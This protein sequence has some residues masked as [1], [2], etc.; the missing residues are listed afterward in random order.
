M[1]NHG[2]LPRSGKDIDLA[3]IQHATSH[4]FNYAPD[5]FN[6]AFQMVQDFHLSTTGNFSTFNLQDVEKHD[7]IEF[8]G[9][10]SRNDHYFGDNLHFDPAIWRTVAQ[11]LDLY[12]VPLFGKG[13]F[14]TLDAA[15]KAWAARVKEAKSVN[16]VFNSSALE[17]M[18][19]PGTTALYLTTL[20]DYDVGAAS[21]AWIRAFFGMF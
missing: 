11:D 3:A 10:L 16:P 13:R 5:T 2:W 4:A 6:S 20:W 12:H 7:A 17:I 8:D 19:S 1:A 18:G 14:V 21:K 9:S 15:A